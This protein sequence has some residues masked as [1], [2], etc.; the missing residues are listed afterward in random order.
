MQELDGLFSFSEIGDKIHIMRRKSRISQDDLSYKAGCSNSTLCLYERGKK[1]STFTR[2][3]D[4]FGALGYD[5]RL[6]LIPKEGRR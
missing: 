6:T 4:I 1:I 5:V 3:E 2:L